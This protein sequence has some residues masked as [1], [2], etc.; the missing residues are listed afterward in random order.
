[1]VA[2]ADLKKSAPAAGPANHGGGEQAGAHVTLV[3]R[4]DRDLE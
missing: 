3:L 4:A 1:M 2:K